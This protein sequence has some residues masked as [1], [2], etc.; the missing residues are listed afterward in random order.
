MAL[1]DLKNQINAGKDA[2]D[3]FKQTIM[4]IDST[5]KSLGVTIAE[6]IT[7]QTKKSTEEVQKLA[8]SYEKDVTQGLAR[9]SKF[10][11]ELLDIQKSLNAGAKLTAA[12]QK[13]LDAAEKDRLVTLRKIEQAK[14]E[15]IVLDAEELVALDLAFDKQRKITSAIEERAE[16]QEA[17]LGIV[18]KISSA[19]TGLLDKLGMGSLNKFFNLDKANAQSKIQLEN[20]AKSKN[21]SVEQLGLSDRIKTVT[22]NITKN[23]DGAAAKAGALLAIA[24]FLFNQFVK[25]DEKIVDLQKNFSLSREEA[26]KLKNE[27]GGAVLEGDL[28][29][30][31]FK[32]NL[33]A[34]KALNKALGGTAIIFD[35]EAN[36]AAAEL[37]SRLG[38]S[39]ESTGE[40]SKLAF[41]TGKPLKNLAI[42]SAE[43][44]RSAEKEFGIRLNLKNVLE[45]AGKITGQTR[46]NLDKFPG[47]LTKA[48]SV[49]KS[50]GVEMDAIA[51]A[52]GQLLD[53]QTSIEK[54]MEAELLLG[55]NLNL[56]AARQAALV[57]DQEGLMRE[58][59]REAGSLEEL[60][61]MN[62]IQQQALAAA[63]GLS[64]DQLS[65]QV[66]N[67]EALAAQ[68]D[69][70]LKKEEERNAAEIV[71]QETALTLADKQRIAT[72]NLASTV[73]MLGGFMLVFAGA[74]AAAAIAL[75]FGVAS[76]AILTGI[77]LTGA[78]IGALGAGLAANVEDGVAPPGK[79]PFTITD[80]FGA[81]TVTAAGDGIAVSPNIQTGNTGDDKAAKELMEMKNILKTIA[82]KPE[83]KLN[84]DSIQVG[85]VAG[86]SA[87]PIQ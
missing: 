7:K 32:E 4:D 71:R 79:G 81:T 67:G 5:L 16:A 35:K 65:D 19:L 76:G 51:G 63:L 13:K 3:D 20:L 1:D 41:A 15:G 68:K 86:L 46:L 87:F 57:G 24:K 56:E 85:T 66:L 80:K 82:N 60:Q 44:L 78:A 2:A 77:V 84:M 10:N 40:L 73:Q 12:Q 9:A 34:A 30:I 59:V 39:A 54:E 22:G 48:V 70:E 72:E 69:E 75:S 18:G 8:A 33:E 27:F 52:A 83:P 36:K 23:F 6:A 53:F 43:Q 37:Q 74:A 42:T 25:A 31:T 29:G 21:I 26:T 47:G 58:L 45:D 28:L 11:D 49:A 62:V 61:N 14:Q 38:V 64:V 55:R 50:L 17:S